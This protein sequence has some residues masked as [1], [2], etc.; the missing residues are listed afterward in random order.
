MAKLMAFLP[1]FA[2]WETINH[3]LSILVIKLVF[4]KFTVVSECTLQLLGTSKVRA[5]LYRRLNST[6]D[7]SAVVR[8]LMMK[9][10]DREI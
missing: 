6:S 3:S 7:D 8:K 5:C 4:V 10:P 1:C 2:W 9:Q